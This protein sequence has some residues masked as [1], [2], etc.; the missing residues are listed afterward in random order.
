MGEV[1]DNFLQTGEITNFTGFGQLPTKY[2]DDH[3]SEAPLRVMSF[4]ESYGDMQY[5]CKKSMN[6]SLNFSIPNHIKYMTDIFSSFAKY[7]F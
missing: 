7:T 4:A 1:Y 2:S 3:Y 5:T 6:Y